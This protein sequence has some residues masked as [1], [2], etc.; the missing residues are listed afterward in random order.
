MSGHGTTSDGRMRRPSLSKRVREGVVEVI[1]IARLAPSRSPNTRAAV[2]WMERMLLWHEGVQEEGR[3][4]RAAR[5]ASAE[6][7]A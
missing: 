6:R 5:R 1:A 2:E 7:A 3:Q 4:A